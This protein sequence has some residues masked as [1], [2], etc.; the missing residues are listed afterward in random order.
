MP[1]QA[2]DQQTE[3]DPVNLILNV[4]WFVFGGF[5]TGLSWL[6]GAL[7]LA[8]TIAGLPWARAAGRIGLFAFAP[9]GR[10]I[11]DRREITGRDDLGSGGL[12]VLLNIVWFV[13]GG[14]HIALAHVLVGGTLCL[15]I[16]GIPFGYQHFKLA[17]IA[18]APVGKSVVRA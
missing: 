5:I 3:S 2:S 7:L 11:V 8:I 16:I 9:F 4:L 15:T 1:T 14:W 13:L 10:R 12:G 6:L 17:L 18:L